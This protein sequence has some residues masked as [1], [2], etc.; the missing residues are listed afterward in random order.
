M[1]S[2][3][4]LRLFCQLDHDEA[5][6]NRSPWEQL[7]ASHRLHHSMAPN[8][9]LRWARIE[10]AAEVRASD[11]LERGV[12]E[13]RARLFRERFLADQDAC[14]WSIA[15]LIVIVSAFIPQAP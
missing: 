8:I 7:V 12:S 10:V 2:G 14:A 13:D 11:L 15:A 6:A 3:S 4:R 1:E 9:V 5:I